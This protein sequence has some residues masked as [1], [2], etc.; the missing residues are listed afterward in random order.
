MGDIQ[1][2]KIARKSLCE[3]YNL[4]IMDI[5]RAKTVTIHSLSRYVFYLHGNTI[6]Y[7]MTRKHEIVTFPYL[8]YISPFSFWYRSLNFLI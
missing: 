2:W 5:L 4:D 8:S 7:I 3:V 6:K 1:I